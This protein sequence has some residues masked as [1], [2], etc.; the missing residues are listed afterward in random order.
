MN[1]PARHVL[2]TATADGCAR[3]PLTPVRVEK[4]QLLPRLVD[5]PGALS[6]VALGTVARS[7]HLAEAATAI[8][9]VVPQGEAFAQRPAR[10]RDGGMSECRAMTSVQVC[11]AP[12]DLLESAL[13][14]HPASVMPTLGVYERMVERVAE[15]GTLRAIPSAR[16]RLAATLRLLGGERPAWA[17]LAVLAEITGLRRETVCRALRP[18]P[19]SRAAE[20]APSAESPRPTA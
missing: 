18:S 11:F 4:H 8:F 19:R 20:K 3:C 13:E 5:Q 12:P 14:Q 10:A 7:R 17:S 16:D 6:F 9:D 2:P 15:L 1:C